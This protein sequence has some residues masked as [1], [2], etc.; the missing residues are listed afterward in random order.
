MPSRHDHAGECAHVEQEFVARVRPLPLRAWLQRQVRLSHGAIDAPSAEDCRLE[1]AR[2]VM[3]GDVEATEKMR[4]TAARL[5]ATPDSYHL[6][7]ALDDALLDVLA[8]QESVPLVKGG[9]GESDESAEATSRTGSRIA[10][11]FLVLVVLAVAYLLHAQPPG[12][13]Q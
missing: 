13:V 8:R 2:A 12:G 1:L 7:A 3:R 6:H 9:Q 10:I 11:A 4:R 5:L